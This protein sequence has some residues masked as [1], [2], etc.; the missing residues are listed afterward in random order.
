MFLVP[1]FFT[2]FLMMKNNFCKDQLEFFL[3]VN[4]IAGFS[5]EK[6]SQMFLVG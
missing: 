2:F 6:G 1:M 4:K 3:A 5:F